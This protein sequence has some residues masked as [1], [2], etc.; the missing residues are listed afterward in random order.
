MLIAL[1]TVG[2]FGVSQQ[3]GAR[4]FWVI[5]VAEM[6]RQV[7]V[8]GSEQREKTTLRSRLPLTTRPDNTKKQARLKCTAR[9]EPR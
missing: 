2:G 4:V 7:I 3:S 6:A 5:A 9:P 1:L 8:V